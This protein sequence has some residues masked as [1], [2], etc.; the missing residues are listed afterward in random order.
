MPT[1]KRCNDPQLED[2]NECSDAIGQNLDDQHDDDVKEDNGCDS[3]QTLEER[4]VVDEADDDM[5]TET[6]KQTQNAVHFQMKHATKIAKVLGCSEQLKEFDITL[7]I[8]RKVTRE[9]KRQHQCL[10]YKLQLA[11]QQIRP[12]LLKDLSSTEKQYFLRHYRLPEPHDRTE[13]EE[14]MTAHQQ[15]ITSMEYKCS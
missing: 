7:K 14:I 10:L 6:Q 11:V 4:A 13:Y 2:H 5:N 12:T 8:K 15:T 9:D 1:P 3:T